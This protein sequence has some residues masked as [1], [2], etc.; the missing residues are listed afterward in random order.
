[1]ML[2]K[3]PA[4]RDIHTIN[5]FVPGSLDEDILS[6]MRAPP[7]E[8]DANKSA[9]GDDSSSEGERDGKSALPRSFPGRAVISPSGEF[10]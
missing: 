7:D 6:H 3:A 1:M 10:Y 4:G 5:S 9:G 2:A 8:E